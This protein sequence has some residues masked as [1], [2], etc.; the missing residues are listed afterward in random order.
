MAFDE[1]GQA[2]NLER[3][4]EICR[5]RLRHPRRRGRLPRRGR[6]LRPQHLR[7]GH[8]HRGA[9]RLRHRLHRGDPLDQGEPAARAGLRR[10]LQRV[11]LVPRQQRGARGDPRRVPL[12]RHPGGHGH[13]HRQRR[14]ARRLRPV[15]AELRERIEDVV[16]NRRPDSTERLLEI[17]E[18]FNTATE[19]GR[20]SPRG[21]ALAAGRRAHHARAG[22]GHRRVR[23]RATPRSCGRR[24]R[25]AA[26]DRSRSSRAR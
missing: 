10:R 4:Q 14:C 5:A 1:E 15:D 7:G 13:G 19:R 12:P 24:S 20:R 16:L 25:R 21:V 3:R 18:R 8:R 9:R 22:Q 23:R 26:G 2:D 11:V 17:A 6:H